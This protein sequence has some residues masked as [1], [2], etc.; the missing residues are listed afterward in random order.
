MSI[1]ID[2]PRVPVEYI[3]RARDLVRRLERSDDIAVVAMA[4]AAYPLVDR[5]RKEH[6]TLRAE[7]LADAARHWRINM[8][9]FGRLD[10]RIEL[11]RKRLRI[12]ERRCSAATMTDKRW[13]VTEPG[14]SVINHVLHAEP[15]NV[16]ARV[17]LHAQIGLHALARR[18]QRDPRHT[19]DDDL[20]ADLLAVADAYPALVPIAPKTEFK[21]EAKFGLWIGQVDAVRN[22]GGY[23]VKIASVR[24][25]VDARETHR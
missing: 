4:A 7:L 8:P 10:R 12:N 15:H 16:V 23:T 1:T 22:Q 17:E 25:F 3:G 13:T 6:R 11:E 5:H 21:I 14:V 2:R 18:Y 9:L 19:T 20:F 24:T